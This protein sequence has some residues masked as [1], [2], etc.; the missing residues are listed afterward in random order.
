M[1]TLADIL[2]GVP[3]LLRLGLKTRFRL[4]GAYWAWRW[5]T[6]F[7]RGK[8]ESTRE[9]LRAAVRYGRWMGRMRRLG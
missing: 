2:L 3:E 4:R 9:M 7:G 1:R 6:A 8:P 5:H